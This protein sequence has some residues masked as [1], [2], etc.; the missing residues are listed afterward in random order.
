MKTNKVEK[1]IGCRFSQEEY[2]RL[3]KELDLTG[4]EISS[5][6][7]QYLPF[8]TD[9]SMPYCY[10][11][12]EVISTIDK[13]GGL[14]TVSTVKIKT[15]CPVRILKRVFTHEDMEINTDPSTYNFTYDVTDHA[16]GHQF[17]SRMEMKTI[18]T[19]LQGGVENKIIF[20][21]PIP[22]KQVFYFTSARTIETLYP[23]YRENQKLINPKWRD[24]SFRD[25]RISQPCRSFKFTLIFP[26]NYPIPKISGDYQISLYI[27]DRDYN[28]APEREKQIIEDQNRFNIIEEKTE[29]G[30]IIKA[31]LSLW[32]PN[33]G[34]LYFIRWLLPSNKA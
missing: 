7:R 4:L 14:E 15:H 2:E 32:R 18:N 3:K 8:K 5:Y 22:A 9:E 23:L 28:D 34:L 30:N 33:T 29:Q 16:G 19:D 13:N 26:P 25:I 17:V 11:E 27:S 24:Y 10:E 12:Y 6:F 20:D 1:R 21:P 31:N